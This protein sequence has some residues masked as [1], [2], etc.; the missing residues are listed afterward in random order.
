MV[1]LLLLNTRSFVSNQSIE[2]TVGDESTEIEF[3]LSLNCVTRSTPGRFHGPPE[4]CYDSE[5]AEFELSS[6]SVINAV[7]NPISISE[8]AVAAIVGQEP[9]NK[10]LEDAQVD[11][12][13][14][15]EF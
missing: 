10:M 2:V 11:A 1:G 4:D 6:I 5:A 14:N 12:D 13:E 7:G 15:G 8:N 9:F 3:E